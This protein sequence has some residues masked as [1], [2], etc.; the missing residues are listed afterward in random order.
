MGPNYKTAVDA[1][2]TTSYRQGD[3]SISLPP[4][5]VRRRAS[6]SVVKHGGSSRRFAHIATAIAVLLIYGCGSGGGGGGGSDGGGSGGNNSGVALPVVP[7]LSGVWAGAWQGTDPRLGLV[8]GTWQSEIT[9]SDSSASGPGELLGDVDCMDGVLHTAAGQ[10]NVPTGTFI[11]TRCGTINWALTALNLD[12]G[13]AAGSWTNTATGGAG[14]LSGVRIAKLSGPRIRFVYPPGG[15]PGTVVTVVGQ[16][17]SDPAGPAQLRFNET[18][19]PSLQST[20]ASRIVARVPIGAITGTLQVSTSAGVARSPQL[21]STDVISPPA[22]A[23]G[24]IIHGSAPAALAV[25]P[26]GRKIYVADRLNASV[27]VLRAVSLSAL[28]STPISGGIPRSVVAGADGKRIYVAANGIGV[29]VMDAALAT[30]LYTIPLALDDGGRDNPQGLAISPD[31]SFLLVSDGSPGGRVSVLRVADNTLVASMTFPAGIAPLGVAFSPDGEQA[32]VAAAD[33]GGSGANTL[34]IFDPSTGAIV[35]SIPV[36][37]LPTGIAVSP[38]AQRVFVSNQGDNSVTLYDTATRSVSTTAVGRAPTG[39]AYGPDGT[40]VYVAN[41]DSNTVSVLTG[42]SLLQTLVTVPVGQAPIA[43]S[44]NPRGTSAYVANVT[45]HTVSELGGMRTLTVALNGGGIGSVSSLPAGIQCGTSCQA[46]FIAGSRITLRAVAGGGSY[47][48]GWSG[49]ADCTDGVVDLNLNRNCIATFI[50]NSPPPSS[51]GTTGS[52]PEGCFIATAAYGSALAPEVQMLRV[53]RDR[54]LMTNAPGRF[55]VRL[56]YRFSP[57]LAEM[58]RPHDGVRAIVR[59][60][61]WPLV[62]SIGHPVSAPCVLLLSV[63]VA[64]SRRGRTA[65]RKDWECS[66]RETDACV[67]IE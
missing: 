47:F 59:I 61:L 36:G 26:D 65:S 17:L 7:D 49:D 63:F 21:F 41:R 57:A 14:T 53:F 5:C 51:G 37:A 46:Q 56:Y 11:R 4:P 58:I 40:Q 32:Y 18:G 31:G 9:Q 2:A 48:S 50:S 12:T 35:D 22:I 43:I 33:V 27:S 38:D 28:T 8:T 42:D 30:L 3:H 20:Q 16:A 13:S 54:R 29:L 62:W 39:I 60:A 10:Q 19:Q 25:S 64:L 44:I 6:F 45:S 66:N 15:R 52:S 24:M 55:L 67:V 34:R 1:T 23:A